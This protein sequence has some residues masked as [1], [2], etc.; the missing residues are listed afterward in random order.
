MASATVLDSTPKNDGSSKDRARAF[1]IWP[2]LSFSLDITP[3]SCYGNCMRID[4]ESV[5]LAFPKY[6][7]TVDDKGWIY[8]VW[9]CGTSWQKVK[10]HGEYPPTFLARALALFPDAKD[11]LHAPSGAVIGPGTTLDAISDDNRHPQV[12]MWF[13][14]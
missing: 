13:F 1:L 5:N 3:H 6:P 2:A 10:L 8:G 7:M 4:V 9:Y 11:I 14:C 12:A